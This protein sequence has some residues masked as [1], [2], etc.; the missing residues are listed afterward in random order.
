MQRLSEDAI[1]EGPPLAL[2]V[3][4]GMRTAAFSPDETKLA[5]LKGRWVA[6]VWRVPILTDR[7]ATWDDAQQLTFDEA[8]VEYMDVSPDGELLAINSDRG[9][10]ADLWTMPVAGGEMTQITTD[11]RPDWSPDGSEVAFYSMRSGNRDIWVLPSSGGAAR[12][13]TT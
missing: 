9:G 8:Y 7:V 2:T 10:N 12:Q 11:P 6:N 1:P 3:G 5:Y 13:I 4:I